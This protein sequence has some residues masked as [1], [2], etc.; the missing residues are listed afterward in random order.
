MKK[1]FQ[2]MVYV[3]YL[4]NEISIVKKQ[5]AE[6]PLYKVYLN[7]GLRTGN[8]CFAGNFISHN[9]CIDA[10]F[11][12]AKYLAVKHNMRINVFFDYNLDDKQKVDRAIY[13]INIICF[14]AIA[15]GVISFCI[16][17]VLN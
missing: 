7:H 5:Q 8:I 3:N 2:Y 13:A 16:W 15:I 17:A 9:D 11:E 6:S 10:G 4:E 12:K 14:S 1:E